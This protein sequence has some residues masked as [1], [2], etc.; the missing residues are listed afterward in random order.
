M[1][2][3][4]IQYAV[5]VVFLFLL[6][7]FMTGHIPGYGKK[8]KRLLETIDTFEACDETGFK[9]TS[10]LWPGFELIIFDDKKECALFES[11]GDKRCVLTYT[12]AYKEI[13]TK[14][15]WRIVEKYFP[16]TEKY[17]TQLQV[18]W[19]TPYLLSD[20]PKCSKFYENL[21]RELEKCDNPVFQKFLMLIKTGV[22]NFSPDFDHYGFKSWFSI[23]RETGWIELTIR[24]KHPLDEAKTYEIFGKNLTDVKL[25]TSL[26]ELFKFIISYEGKLPLKNPSPMFHTFPEYS[27]KIY[28]QVHF[29]PFYKLPKETWGSTGYTLRGRFEM[30]AH[31]NGD[32]EGLPF[33]QL[34]LSSGLSKEEIAGLDGHFDWIKSYFSRDSDL[35]D[36]G[37]NCTTVS[38]E[39]EYSDCGY[40]FTIYSLKPFDTKVP[41]WD[42]LSETQITLKQ[43]LLDALTSIV[44]DYAF[45]TSIGMIERGG[46]S[47]II[48]LKNPK[49]YD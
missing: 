7:Y 43:A 38:M 13:M 3:V 42:G 18:T 29:G 2:S 46:A 45:D 24:S 37:F 25:F 27:E 14:C 49:F 41:I 22:L 30:T 6:W 23:N 20:F 31:V 32:E 36:R 44:S 8:W 33:D 21:I 47:W 16:Y 28:S 9:Y 34:I 11:E 17:K 26:I 5:L 48:E 4:I 40:N 12:N 19:G 39:T 35:R 10:K 1:T 15:Y